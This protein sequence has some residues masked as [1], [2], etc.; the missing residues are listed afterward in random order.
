MHSEKLVRSMLGPT[1]PTTSPICASRVNPS[2]RSERCNKTIYSC[3]DTFWNGWFQIFYLIGLNED[4][5]V[6]N[7]DSQHEERNDF[8]DD[9][10]GWHSEV[11]VHTERAD[12]RQEDENDTRQTERNLRV[13]LK[14][15]I[16]SSTRI[17]MMESAR[18]LDLPT[19]LRATCT[20]QARD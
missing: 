10:G 12:D 18:A 11:A 16:L 13:N 8:N 3:V 15:T 5:D 6:V 2:G 19:Q 4:E 7:T 1:R 9:E 17:H 14:Q 20:G